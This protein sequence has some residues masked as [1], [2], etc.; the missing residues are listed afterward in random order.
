M[1]SYS[2]PYATSGEP[3]RYYPR[4]GDQNWTQQTYNV[5]RPDLEVGYAPAYYPSQGYSTGV[6]MGRRNSVP[7]WTNPKVY[8]DPRFYNESPDWTSNTRFEK[9]YVSDP[10]I[11]GNGRMMRRTWENAA[12]PPEKGYDAAGWYRY[13][14]GQSEIPLDRLKSPDVVEDID[15]AKKPKE[16]KLWR[17]VAV[18]NVNELTP[19]ILDGG[20]IKNYGYIK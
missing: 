15:E 8:P 17:R 12:A 4:S 2:R 3:S 6:A 13:K 11:R 19:K 10:Q 7:W 16:W 14:R 5:R 18:Q 9:S 1:T 20:Y